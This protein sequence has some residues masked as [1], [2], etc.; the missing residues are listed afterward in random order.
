MSSA[1][2]ITDVHDAASMRR[3]EERTIAAGTSGQELMLSAGIAAAREIRARY[4]AAR[5]VAVLCGG[6]GNGGDG[7]IVAMQLALAGRR[8]RVANVAPDPPEGDAAWARELASIDGVTFSSGTYG[9]GGALEDAELVVDAMLGIGASGEPRERVAF[10]IGK[11]ASLGVPIV[12]LDVPSGVDA[13]TGEVAGTAVHA[14]LTVAFGAPK[15]GLL[16]EPGRTC[17]GELVVAEIGV[18]PAEGVATLVDGA[19]RRLLPAVSP[20]GSKYDRGT[21]L[22]V[23]GSPGMAGAAVLAGRAAQRGGAGMVRICI[24]ERAAGTVAVH[25]VEQLVVALPRRPAEAVEAI[26]ALA[27]RRQ[28]IVL[29]PGLGRGKSRAELVA[30][31]LALP[32]PAVVDADGL[33]ALG[34]SPERLRRRAVPTVITPHAGEAARLLGVPSGEVDA[35]RLAS[36]RALAERSGHTALLKGSDTLVASPDGRLAIRGGTCDALGTAGSGDVLAGLIGALLARGLEA[37][38]AAALG[39]WLHLDAGRRAVEA[40]PGRVL[41]AS[42]LPDAL[43]AG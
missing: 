43:R 7:Y 42:D 26:A 34:G 30:G 6:G 32:I 35:H 27:G 4:P 21:V 31:V 19:A 37:H 13:S 28:A 10:A 29:G 23:A 3:A 22:V 20:S 36:V 1:P 11:A 17:T 14:D 5:R 25:V 12:A 24:D 41:V 9:T 2:S 18:N 38:D 40:H 15:L 8:V 33:Y 16:V 39:A